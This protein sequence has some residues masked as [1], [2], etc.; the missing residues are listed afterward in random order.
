[1]PR[2]GSSYYARTSTRTFTS[3]SIPRSS[4]SGIGYRG[5]Y[6]LPRTRYLPRGYA[7]SAAYR[8][9]FPA[10]HN[11]LLIGGRYFVYYP[12]LPV[13][14]R[15]FLFGRRVYYEYDGI[16]YQTY[17]YEGTEVYLVVPPPMEETL[18]VPDEASP[19]ETTPGG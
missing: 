3:A 1:L 4:R 19:G 14:F 17:D 12:F 6:S 8:N 5:N 7:Y 11:R 10:G 13:G 18:P 15:T 9:R 16:Y 2:P